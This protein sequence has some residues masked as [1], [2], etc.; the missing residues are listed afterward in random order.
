MD[1]AFSKLDT[2][3]LD[4]V[5]GVAVAELRSL[6]C[7]RAELLAATLKVVPGSALVIDLVIRRVKELDPVKGPLPS[8]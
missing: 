5:V 1:G 7:K 3:V 8:T 4:L 2:R 6:S